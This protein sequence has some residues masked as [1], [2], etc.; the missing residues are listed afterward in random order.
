MPIAD[1]LILS[2]W[3]NF[4][5]IVTAADDRKTKCNK[6]RNRMIRRIK[7]ARGLDWSTLK[8]SYSSVSCHFNFSN[9]SISN[10]VAFGLSVVNG[11]NDS[12][13]TKEMQLIHA[14]G[15]LNPHGIN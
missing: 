9:Y 4:E 3:I 8:D 5:T 14:L 12:C 7:V 11:G 10:F 2:F 6:T 15:T 13:K 1:R